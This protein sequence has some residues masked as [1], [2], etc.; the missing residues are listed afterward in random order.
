MAIGLNLI[1]KTAGALFEKTTSF[2]S[3]RINGLRMVNKKYYETNPLNPRVEIH[4]IASKNGNTVLF[5]SKKFDN[6]NKF[7][8]YKLPDEI[9]KVL[10][11]KFG[12][13]KALK[14]S[15]AQHNENPQKTYENAKS[16]MASQIHNFLG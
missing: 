2:N 7:E 14:S 16:S 6:G 15:I 11:N 9:I 10:K 1:E 3:P 12:E 4:K 5:A 13:I 8:L